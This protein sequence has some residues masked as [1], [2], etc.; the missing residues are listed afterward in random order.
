MDDGAK[1]G[2]SATPRARET[3]LRLATTWGPDCLI[4]TAGGA[5]DLATPIICT[6]R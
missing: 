6:P 5:V 3:A 1:D 2:T 4:V